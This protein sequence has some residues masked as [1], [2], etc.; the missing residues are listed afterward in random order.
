LIPPWA[1]KAAR[2]IMADL[3]DRSGLGFDDVDDE[4][5]KEIARAI[6][7]IIADAAPKVAP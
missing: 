6:A 2:K 4:I 7:E 1:K 5:R 3:D